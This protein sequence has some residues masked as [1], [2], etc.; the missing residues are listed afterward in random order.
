MPNM[1]DIL[2]AKASA[3]HTIRPEATVLEATRKMTQHKV[4]ALVVMQ[5]NQVVGIFTERD[6]L[7]RVVVQELDPTALCVAEVMT[8]QVICADA[9]TDLE[10]AASIMKTR[11]IRHLPICDIDGAL[12]GMISIGDLNALYAT[13]QEQTIHFLNDYIYGRV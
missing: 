5:D 12:L 11:R 2:S 6:V 8:C 4:G 7:R 10:E 1:Q 3:I 9:D 13:A